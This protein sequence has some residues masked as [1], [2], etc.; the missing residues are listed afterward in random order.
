MK[1]KPIKKVSDKQKKELAL[2][3]QLKKELIEESNGRCMSCG[4]PPYEFPFTLDLSHII[5]LS[6]GGKTTRDNCVVECRACHERHHHIR[7]RND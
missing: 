7:R 2:R 3:S 4:Q 5:P 6:R 1:K